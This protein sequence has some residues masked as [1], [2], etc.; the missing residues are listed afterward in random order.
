MAALHQS[1]APQVLPKPGMLAVERPQVL[2]GHERQAAVGDRPD[3]AVQVLEVQ[4]V[5][6]GSVIDDVERHDLALAAR[7]HLGGAHHPFGDKAASGGTV[8][9][10]RDAL[11]GLELD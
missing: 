11:V 6:V 3:V 8:A 7:D 2:V 5:Q 9:L 1:G 10:A 4:A